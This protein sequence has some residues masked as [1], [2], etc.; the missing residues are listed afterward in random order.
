MKTFYS[1]G[2]YLPRDPLILW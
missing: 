1:S 2:V